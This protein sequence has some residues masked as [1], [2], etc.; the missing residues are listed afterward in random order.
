LDELNQGL[1]D[2]GEGF[3]DDS[4]HGETPTFLLKI[5]TRL[6]V[7]ILEEV[8]RCLRIKW[9]EKSLVGK[10]DPVDNFSEVLHGLA[11]ELV[12]GKFGEKSVQVLEEKRELIF[13]SQLVEVD[14]RLGKGIVLKVEIVRA[15]EGASTCE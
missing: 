2:V 1:E 5:G 6:L 11:L 15:V 14:D 3:K 8:E 7:R 13:Q 10:L 9:V 4:L 12:E